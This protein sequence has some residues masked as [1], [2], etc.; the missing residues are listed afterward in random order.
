MIKKIRPQRFLKYLIVAPY[1]M[2]I[3]ATT[4]I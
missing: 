2:E 4:V 3:L 1:E